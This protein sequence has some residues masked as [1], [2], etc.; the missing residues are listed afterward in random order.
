MKKT[1]TLVLG[2]ALLPPMALGALAVGAVGVSPSDVAR[3]V[4][5]AFT[6]SV[7]GH[8]EAIIV[9]IRLPRV[10]M[11]ALVGAALALSGAVLQ[12]LFRN[13]L[14]EPSLIGVSNGATLGAVM[15]IVYLESAMRSLMPLW[16]VK[17]ALPMFAFVFALGVTRLVMRL[18]ARG[19]KTSISTLLLTG[20]A[21]N[22]WIGALVGF[23]FYV[24]TDVQ[25]RA[26]TFWTLGSLSGSGWWSV[27]VLATFLAFPLFYVPR[28]SRQLNAMLLG[29]A[30]ATH[31]GVKVEKVKRRAVAAVALAVGAATAFTGLIGFVG[32][33]VPQILR[34]WLGPD[35]KA[36][37]PASALYGAIFLLAADA[38]A[39][40]LAA[41][42][43]LPIGVLTAAIG[44]P[45]FLFLLQKSP[46]I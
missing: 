16:G 35:H 3:A 10:V 2:G 21:M 18:A 41:P 25:I 24:G 9:N 29:E 43:E 5:T 26:I 4:A 36:L 31:L 38:A 34:L 30:E 14:A 23:M 32:L 37:L 40:T 6:G 33:I 28:L 45:V 7:T 19:G 1:G 39:R 22:A 20:V 12:G 27:G 13:P 15:F 8:T 11:A 44:A 42:A 17:F 46:Q